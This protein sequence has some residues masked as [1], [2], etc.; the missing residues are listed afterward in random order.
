MR[1]SHLQS[2]HWKSVRTLKSLARTLQSANWKGVRTL[3]SSART[4][5][6]ANFLTV[7]VEITTATLKQ[8]RTA[9]VFCGN[10]VHTLPGSMQNKFAPQAGETC[11]IY[12][13]PIRIHLTPVPHVW[14]TP[15]N[16]PSN[17][18]RVGIHQ[19]NKYY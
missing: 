3:K 4:L 2:T 14:N 13:R 1:N 18:L 10:K 15:S 8:V 12:S 7:S 5:R 11:P 6:S 9:Y 16:T 19:Q 17:L